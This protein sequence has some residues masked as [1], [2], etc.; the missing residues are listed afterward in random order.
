MAVHS[1]TTGSITL[2]DAAGA[3]ADLITALNASRWSIDLGMETVDATAF[4]PTSNARVRLP[5]LSA[6]SGSAEGFLDDTATIDEA[7]CFNEPNTTIEFVGTADTDR[8]YTGVGYITA[9]AASVGVGE[10]ATWT[11]S[12]EFT[13]AVA[14]A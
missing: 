7:A 11:M 10:T 9:F 4:S 6:H 14:I 3:G 1:G 5:G 2:K 12:F 13:G 8:T